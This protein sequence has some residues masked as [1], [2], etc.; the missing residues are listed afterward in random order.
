MLGVGCAACESAISENG[1]LRE[2]DRLVTGEMPFD[3]FDPGVPRDGEEHRG[4][5][6]EVP[7]DPLGLV[8]RLWMG[9]PRRPEQLFD[10]FRVRADTQAERQLVCPA[11]DRDPL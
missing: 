1:H 5:T 9:L 6:L 3:T 10:H 4:G 7:V 8:R 2:A 11:A